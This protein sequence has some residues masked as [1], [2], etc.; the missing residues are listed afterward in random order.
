M[1]V[2]IMTSYQAII[3]IEFLVWIIMVANVT[4][5]G[6]CIVTLSMLEVC[7]CVCVCVSV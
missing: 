5:S 7:V 1:S 2:S 6:K 4:V 3:F